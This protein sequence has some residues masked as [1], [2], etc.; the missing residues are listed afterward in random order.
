LFN[1]ESLLINLFGDAYALNES[2]VYSLQ[3]SHLRKPEQ[4]YASKVALSKDLQDIVGYVKT[5]RDSLSNEVFNSQEFSVK[6]IQIPKISNTNRAD[7]AVEFVR[8]DELSDADKEAFE[9]IAAIVKDRKVRVEATNV[10]KL[11]PSGV[12]ASVL[13]EYP[14]S[15]FN[16]YTHTCLAKLFEIR[17]YEEDE[18][19]F[20]TDTKFCHYDE[21]HSDYV[22][23]EE[24][25]ELI[26]DL[27]QSGRISKED[28]LD[29][30]RDD[31]KWDVSEF[32]A[33][34]QN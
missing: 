30:Y 11:K 9:K 3:F 19:P 1:Y 26:V 22:Y 29:A 32:I 34:P 5:F 10:G 31:E 25:V 14:A 8:W 23:T 21:V 20:D 33:Q 12:V 7:L 13:E 15:N 18:D 27:F 4:K 28:I 2:L 17:P 16:M 6:L 24:W